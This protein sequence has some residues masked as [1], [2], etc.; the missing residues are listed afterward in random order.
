MQVLAR[1]A[2]HDQKAAQAVCSTAVDLLKNDASRD[3]R[4]LAARV[5]GFC[6]SI[7]PLRTLIATLRLRDFGVVHE[8]ERSLM[9]LTGTAFAYNPRQWEQWLAS[10]D[11][12]FRYRG[13]LD[14]KLEGRP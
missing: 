1:R 7:E 11:D 9:R 6:P 5:L 3:V 2:E 8:A 14:A 13:R 10:T 12:P 4:V